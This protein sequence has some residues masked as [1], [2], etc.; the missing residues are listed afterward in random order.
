MAAATEPDQ[1]RPGWN[2]LTAFPPP[3]KQYCAHCWRTHSPIDA[4]ERICESCEL[5][6]FGCV[7]QY[8]AECAAR[9]CPPCQ[10]RCICCKS[11]YCWECIPGDMCKRCLAPLH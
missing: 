1:N 8:C 5:P 9:I 11:L 7:V 4:L 10:S 3:L 6:E 2:F